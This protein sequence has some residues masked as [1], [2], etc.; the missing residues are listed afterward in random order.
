[1]PSALV[2]HALSSLGET[3]QANLFLR[4]FAFAKIPM[5]LWV[6]ARIVEIDDD[7]CAVRI[8][9][10]RRTRNHLRSMYFGVLMVGADIAGGLMAFRNAQRAGQRISFAFK[11]VEAQFLKRAEHDA[12]F[13]CRDGL[14]V[15]NMLEETVRTGQRVNRPVKVVATTPAVTGQ[16]PVAEFTMVLSVKALG[17]QTTS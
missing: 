16:E 1:M 8:R 4:A 3:R 14:A 7:H 5:I 10:R 17:D 12:Y 9:L 15:Q 13:E 11:S 6:G 2:R